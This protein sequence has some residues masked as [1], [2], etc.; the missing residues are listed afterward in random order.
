MHQVTLRLPDE[1]ADRLKA[2]AADHGRSVNAHAQAVLQAAVDP[3]MAGDEAA[4]LRE[5]LARAGL[6][7]PPTRSAGP[8]PAEAA[9]TAARAA[10]GR[11]RSLSEL[12]GD[13]RG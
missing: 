11:G 6:L 8:R 10:A 12:V 9:L 7:M 1:L 13:G 5:R 3:D 4:R 2:V